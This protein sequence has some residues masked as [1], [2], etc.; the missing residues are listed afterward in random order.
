[1][2]QPTQ[3][4]H[5]VGANAVPNRCGFFRSNREPSL[6]SGSSNFGKANVYRGGGKLETAFEWLFIVLRRLSLAVVE[7]NNHQEPCLGF[8]ERG[9]EFIARECDDRRSSD[10][11]FDLNE[12]EM[13]GAGIPRLDV[14]AAVFFGDVSRLVALFSLVLHHGRHC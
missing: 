2:A 11:T 10:A 9:E 8:V 5:L 3:N 1:M 14:V 12:A 4:R 13:T 7:G 6:E